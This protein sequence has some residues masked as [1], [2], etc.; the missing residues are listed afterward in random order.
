VQ[1]GED[2][3]SESTALMGAT[4]LDM[5]LFKDVDLE[6]DYSVQVPLEGGQRP[7]HHSLIGISVE[8]NSV[9]DLNVSATW[10]HVGSPERDSSG[11]LP[12]KDDYRLIVGLEIEF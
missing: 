9:F 7:N 11:E 2:R 1:P 5:D 3:Y 8:L 10:D 12:E 6:F 4:R